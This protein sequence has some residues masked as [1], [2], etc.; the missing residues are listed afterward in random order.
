MPLAAVEGEL[1]EQGRREMSLPLPEDLEKGIYLMRL[2]ATVTEPGGRSVSSHASATVDL[3]DRHVGLRL[4]EGQVVP[5]GQAVAVDWVRLNG[6]DQPLPVGGM[7]VQLLRMEYDS[8]LKQVGNRYRWQS[9]EKAVKVGSSQV[10]AS[11]SPEGTLE[12]VCP[13]SGRYRVVVTDSAGGSSTQLEFYASHD[14]DRSQNLALNQP[15]RVEVLTDKT[16]YA[17][18]DVAKVLL[19][20]PIPGT[21][22]L[23]LDTD[24]VIVHRIARIAEN[25][26]T[27]DI[28]LPEELRGSVF[29]TATVIRPV[30]PNQESWLP[31]RGLGR[32][33]VRMDHALSKMPVTIRAPGQ[34]RPGEPLTVTVD[35]GPMGDPNYPARV[36]VWAV[37]EGIL[38]A[39]AYETPDLHAFFLGPR[40]LGVHTADVFYGLLPDYRRPDSIGRIG[41]DDYD[42]DALRRSP[43]ATRT[44]EPA[45]IWQEAVAVDSEGKVAVRMQLPDL[46]GQL[47]IMAVALDHDRYGAAEH[48]LTL[49]APLLLE[50]SWPRFAAPGDTFTVPVKL[51]NSTDRSLRLQIKSEVS[52]PIDVLLDEAQRNLVVEPGRPLTRFLQAEARAIGPAEVRIDVVEQGDGEAPLAAHGIGLLAVRPATALHTAVELQ[53]FQVGEAAQIT[54][55]DLF[56]K[57]TVQMT[58]SV[59]ARPSVNLQAALEE[60]IRYPYGCVEQ[61]SSRLFSLVYAKQ[62]L[63]PARAEA[64]DGMVEAGIARLWAMQTRSGGLS[65]WPGQATADPWGTAYAA[66]CLLEAR[67]AGYAIEPRF[68]TALAKYLGSRLRTTGDEGPDE[69]TQALICRVLATFGDPPHGWMARLA[70][71]QH[72]LDV[73]A[74]AHLAGAFHAAGNRERALSLFPEHLP[75]AAVA[76]TTTGRLTSKVQQEAVWLSTLLEIDPNHAMVASLAARLDRARSNGQWGSTLNNAA[77]IAALVRYQALA[78]GDPPQFTGTLQAGAEDPLPF[79]QAEP[80]SLE[81]RH[82]LDPVRISSSGQGRLY[83]VALSRGLV[84]DDLVEP[85]DSGL[86]IKRKWLD[87]DGHPMD[88]NNLVV[89]DLVRVEIIVSTEGDT[90]HN[91]AIVDALPGG[92]EAENPRL[93]TSADTDASVGDTP[94]HVEFLDDRVVL[95]C[96]AGAKPRTYRYALRVITAGEFSLPP[97]QGSCMYDP[98]VACL[99]AASR[100]TVRGQ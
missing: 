93:A 35:A 47:R 51:F 87:R 42:L 86:H 85:Y 96:A 13:V 1:D 19:R 92:L 69:G 67:H 39:A 48:A 9:V 20:S 70:E 28:V 25:T 53:A 63:D 78:S 88:A 61:T 57:E 41:G 75:V 21:V 68:T 52:G 45:V 62:I 16:K 29:F 33:Q 46:A 37:D 95:F 31:H 5:V 66:A 99:G 4:P 84:R 55:S 14:G 10:F 38:L 74:R 71:Q 65:Y 17:P 12:V 3:L 2:S 8:V 72:E 80:V 64:I 34:A 83:V 27:L 73:A 44:R 49:T 58:V 82:A 60:Q 54:P 40:A 22:L 81:V 50:A 79:T 11:D 15:E 26:C 91:V 56:M 7:T 24:R 18:G 32:A 98:A 94:D 77:A 97:I 6:A 90:V 89:G 100:V 23:T 76:T 59:S 30:D 36:Q 43:V